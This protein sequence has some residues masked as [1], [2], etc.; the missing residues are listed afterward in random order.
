MHP[1]IGIAIVSHNTA[2]L[3]RRCLRSV[4]PEAPGPVLVVDNCSTD[5]SVELVQ[6]E[7]PRVRIR[8]E[9]DNRGYGAAANLAV[10][11]L[12]TNYVLL[13]NADTEINPGTAERLV[14]YLE[15]H[16]SVAV[17]GPR[18]VTSR[19]TYEPS[20][21]RFPTPLPLLVAE[22][23]I[24]RLFGLGRRD[25]WRARP[26]DWLLGAALAIRRAAFDE[27]GG[28]DEAYFLYQEEVDLCFRLQAAGWE[29]HY[30]PVATV[31]H[32]GGASTSQQAA[33]A[34]GQYVRSTRRF[35]R[36]W[37]SPARSQG[38][39]AVLGAVLVARAARDLAQLAW[40][41]DRTQRDG[42]RAR[43]AAWRR[44]LLALREKVDGDA[45][46]RVRLARA[47]ARPDAT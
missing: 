2:R 19:G 30:A 24:R 11:E 25:E 9:S 7:F 46:P 18:V 33:E 13:L 32:V 45:L 8:T 31:V 42:L 39:R 23:G 43:L 22:S 1:T 17:A 12:G 36:L 4:V 44:G 6:R 27:V 28:F 35:A 38:V 40:A 41:R 16:P 26:A 15:Q 14:A 3:L 29:V 20:V 10:S 5:G 47:S 34:Y 37:L 21:Y